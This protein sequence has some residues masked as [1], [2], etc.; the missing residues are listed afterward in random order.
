[1]NA[2]NS[3][4]TLALDGDPLFT[5]KS[6]AARHGISVQTLAN[7]R[8][9]GRGPKWVKTEYGVRYRLSDL[10]EWERAFPYG[11]SHAAKK[12]AAAMAA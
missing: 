10:A 8:S 3:P 6:V 2:I 4:V 11:Q 12:A 9:A 7:M 1:M 5:P